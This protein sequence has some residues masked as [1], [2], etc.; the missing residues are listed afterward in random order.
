MSGAAALRPTADRADRVRMREAT[1]RV[2]RIDGA[3]RLRGAA[4]C[5]GLGLLALVCGAGVLVTGAYAIEPERLGEALSGTGGAGF[6]LWR[7][8]TPRLLLGLLVGA[9]F[10]LSGAL[11][12]P[13]LRN[14]L[15]S[16]DILGISGGASAGACFA[17]LMLGAG[18]AGASLGALA[19]GAAA[20]CA[21]MLLS[22]TPPGFRTAQA[23]RILL[24]GV[25][26][27]SLSASTVGFLLARADERAAQQALGWTV[28]GL[29][30]A[31]W[32][33]IGVLAAG[34]AILAPAARCCAPGV[35]LLGCGE[36]LARGLGVRVERTRTGAVLVAVGLASLATAAAGPVSFVAFLSAPIARRLVGHG[37]I[38]LGASAITGAVI[39]LGAELAAQNLLPGGMPAGIVTAVLG[40]PVLLWLVATRRAAGA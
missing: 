30:R 12:Q 33:S 27:A 34:L 19:G 16:P 25:A 14:P 31:E 24:V 39:V 3:A 8:R 10:G 2:A 28:G 17:V 1:E 32:E 38:A 18:G 11:L 7:L 21:I 20:A 37:S 29:A 15:A 6:V 23:S 22:R 40:A 26:V 13:T 35:R 36:Q 4:V 5:F 9:A